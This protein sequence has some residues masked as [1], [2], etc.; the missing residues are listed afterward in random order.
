[1]T[2]QTGSDQRPLAALAQSASARI[3]RAIVRGLYEGVYAPGQRL[4]EPEIM[5]QFGVGRSTARESIR[6]MESEGIVTVVPNRG[7]V[8]RRMSVDEA[9]DALLVMEICVGLAARQAAERINVGGGRARFEQTWRELQKFRDMPDGY[10]FVAARNRFYRA[11]TE[12]SANQELRRIIPSIHI[13][14]IR[15]EYSLTTRARFE[16][17]ARMAEAI[18]A[19][20]GA[21]ADAAARRHIAKTAALVRQ[22]SAG[23]KDRDRA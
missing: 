17:Y 15:R 5:T 20:D 10:D 18:L 21:A 4:A 23:G 7:A 1:M 8:I 14:L 19:G 6:R 9:L 13:H 12:V 22:R 3:V 2:L 16:D 11:I